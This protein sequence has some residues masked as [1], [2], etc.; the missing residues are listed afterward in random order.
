M[1]PLVDGFD[2][3]LRVNRRRRGNDYSIE[4]GLLL[5]HLIEAEVR[6]DT[7]EILI[8]PFEL[9][10]LWRRRR[11]QIRSRSQRMEVIGMTSAHATK[12]GDADLEFARHGGR[13]G[14]VGR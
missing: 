14:E 4:L 13:Q 9:R 2:G 3:L 10:W 5:Q 1:K 6:S 12:S 8:C 11:D 7:I